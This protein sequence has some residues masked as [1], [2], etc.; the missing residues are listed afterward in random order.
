MP[1]N[2]P[3]P[4]GGLFVPGNLHVGGNI[5]SEFY[6]IHGAQ[7]DPDGDDATGAIDDST[8]PFKTIQG[9]IDAFTALGIPGRL[10]WVG[11]E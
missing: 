4:N 8:R 11:N 1:Q 2:E 9:A 10:V 6:G 5:T 7:I 3:H